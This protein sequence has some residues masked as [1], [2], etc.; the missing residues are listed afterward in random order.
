MADVNGNDD[1]ERRDRSSTPPL[2][3]V[4]ILEMEVLEQ[5]LRAEALQHIDAAWSAQRRLMRSCLRPDD[6]QH[7]M[8]IDDVKQK[9]KDLVTRE[10]NLNKRAIE[11]EGVDDAGDD[12]ALLVP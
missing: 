11:G 9:D 6:E 12:D 4:K 2:E 7:G 1:D 3:P 5:L 10:A 8:R